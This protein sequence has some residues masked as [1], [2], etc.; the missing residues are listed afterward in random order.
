MFDANTFLKTNLIKALKQGSFNSGQV[1]IFAFNYLSKGTIT[2]ETFDTIQAGVTA[3]DIEQAKLAE[4]AA[5]AEE[6]QMQEVAE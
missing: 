1:M 2:Q 4:E 6:E 3:Y 5:K